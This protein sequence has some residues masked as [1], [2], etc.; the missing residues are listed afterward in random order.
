MS[1][2]RPFRVTCLEGPPPH[3]Q[4]LTGRLGRDGHVVCF[5]LHWMVVQERLRH[6][7]HWVPQAPPVPTYDHG[8]AEVTDRLHMLRSGLPASPRHRLSET[9][10][11]KYVPPPPNRRA[12]RRL[13]LRRPGH[14]RL[15][16]RH[17]S[18]LGVEPRP[19]RRAGGSALA[20]HRAFCSA[21]ARREA[22]PLR[23]GFQEASP[24]RSV[25]SGGWSPA[26]GAVG[27]PR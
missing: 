7:A 27:G 20:P 19:G 25:I 15:S 12:K 13:R 18:G 8:T 6:E 26:G 1:I 22:P 9:R 11:A 3:A 23:R 5:T 16:P 14:P 24:C 10:A 21:S 2:Q 17:S 4:K